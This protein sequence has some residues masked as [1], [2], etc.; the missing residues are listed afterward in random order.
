VKRRQRI[1]SG[2]PRHFWPLLTAILSRM[3]VV[4][5]KLASVERK[6]RSEPDWHNR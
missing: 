3:A 5:R 2:P 6:E 1:R 4:E